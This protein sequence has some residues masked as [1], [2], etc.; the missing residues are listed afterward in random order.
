MSIKQNTRL[1]RWNSGRIIRKLLLIVQLEGALV[2]VVREDDGVDGFVEVCRCRSV[3]GQWTQH[4]I[5]IL[6]TVVTM[7]PCCAILGCIEN[8][9]EGVSRCDGTL[10]YPR[11]TIHET[12]A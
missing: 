2:V 11:H 10:G 3:D 12:I 5:R 4:A 9:V 8:I 6:K 1:L 7:V